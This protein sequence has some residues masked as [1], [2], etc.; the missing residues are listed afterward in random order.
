MSW[1]E[2]DAGDAESMWIFHAPSMIQLPI[3][4]CIEFISSSI[5]NEWKSI[6]SLSVYGATPF[7]ATLFTHAQKEFIEKIWV[8]FSFFSS[9]DALHKIISIA[10]HFLFSLFRSRALS[11]NSFCN[12]FIVWFEG[13]CAIHIIVALC[14][15]KLYTDA[16][17]CNRS[18]FMVIKYVWQFVW[19]TGDIKKMNGITDQNRTNTHTCTQIIIHDGK[20]DSAKHKKNLQV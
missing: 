1:D 8:L 16:H 14:K 6:W 3:L 9:Q 19:K 12:Y 2:P 13:G 11:R 5:I 18:P 20:S 10:F 17:T 4:L 15:F 7:M